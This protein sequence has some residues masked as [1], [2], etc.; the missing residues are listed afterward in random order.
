MPKYKDKIKLKIKGVKKYIPFP[1]KT[2]ITILIAD[3]MQSR[4]KMYN[5]E[6]HSLLKMLRI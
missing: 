6:I 5:I 3:K 1:K 4:I 2:L